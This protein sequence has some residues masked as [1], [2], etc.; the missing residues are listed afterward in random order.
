MYGEE[1][2][3]SGL[4]EMGEIGNWEYPSWYTE[5]S[6]FEYPD[7]P[8]EEPTWASLSPSLYNIINQNAPTWQQNQARR[9][10]LEQ[11]RV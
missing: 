3:F 8:V 1:N 11:S 6:S 7:W 5:P 2:W 9:R 10:V 4:G